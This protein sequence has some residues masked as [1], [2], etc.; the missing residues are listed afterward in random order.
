VSILRGVAA[1][2]VRWLAVGRTYPSDVVTTQVLPR[3]ISSYN[4]TNIAVLHVNDVY[5]NGYARGMRDNSPAAN[6]NVVASMSYTTN[7]ATT[8]GPGCASLAATGANIIL[9]IAW[10]QDMIPILN[11][12]RSAGPNSVDLLAPGYVWISADSCSAELSHMAGVTSGMTAAHSA[13]LLDGMLNFVAS[14]QGTAG[15]DR[16]QADWVTHGR[17]ECV[18]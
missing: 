17:D 7:D 9:I 4:W 6:V 5:A 12:C 2:A 16:F 3:V 10:D 11:E 13:Q 15:F 1:H 8:F 14:P 18:K